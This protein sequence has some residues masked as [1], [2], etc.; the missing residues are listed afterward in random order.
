MEEKILTD[1]WFDTDLPFKINMTSLTSNRLLQEVL[2][3]RVQ[4]QR[5]LQSLQACSVGM[6]SPMVEAQDLPDRWHTELVEGIVL[7]HEVT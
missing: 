2:I 3:Q 7:G 4:Q 1:I 5:R 6:R